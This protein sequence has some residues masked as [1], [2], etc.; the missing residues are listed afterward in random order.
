MKKIIKIV[1][2]IIIFLILCF[3]GYKIFYKVDNKEVNNTDNSTT[4]ES[5]DNTTDGSTDNST[6]GSPDTSSDNSST[7]NGSS[8]D[9][10]TSSGTS[11][12]T[13]K[14]LTAEEIIAN[15]AVEGTFKDSTSNTKVVFASATGE[16]MME[17][18]LCDNRIATIAGTYSV[19]DKLV[20]LKFK[21]NQY[22]GFTSSKDT[23]YVY[24]I[25]SASKIRFDSAI[26][27][28][29]CGPTKGDYFNK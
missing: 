19:K 4:E 12:T 26:A 6:D 14:T 5:T 2:S 8:T 16:F 18:N 23:S 7:S 11:G 24:T 1:A 9:N 22:T 28:G 29:T 25:M 13:T 20:T 21:A 17:I 3:V 15:N 27:T 10:S